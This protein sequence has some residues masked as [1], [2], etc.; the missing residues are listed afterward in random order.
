MLNFSKKLKISLLLF[1][2]CFTPNLA[3]SNDFYSNSN[4]SYENLNYK[5]ALKG[6]SLKIGAAPFPPFVTVNETGYRE[7]YGIE[8]EILEE[9]KKRLGF[10][11]LNDKY[12][13]ASSEF[14]LNAGNEGSIDIM[15]GGLSLTKERIKTY[16]TSP[17][18]YQS[19]QAIVTRKSEASSIKTFDDLNGKVLATEAGIDIKS[20]L[21]GSN[22]KVTVKEYA[23]NFM[24]YYAI[25]KGDADATIIDT[26]NALFY[27][28]KW[29][30]GNLQ[31]AF[32]TNEGNEE[33]NVGFLYK[34]GFKYT[35]YFNA[36]ISD[37]IS[38]GTVQ[39]IIDK[40]TK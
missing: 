22:A 38:D 2:C 25:S 8:I 39:K 28:K 16:P 36:A 20:W 19:S 13:F 10:S 27:S 12:I 24:S 29:N 5:N 31:I 4:S 15:V 26:P 37:M 17:A 23:T 34:K 6:V 33:S 35:N 18:I 11:L 7:P 21:Q 3:F 9:V 14:V 40:Y 30:F 32:V 1:S